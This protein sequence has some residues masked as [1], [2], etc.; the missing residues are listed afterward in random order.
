MICAIFSIGKKYKMQRLDWMKS[1][2]ENRDFVEVMKK[3]EKI[4]GEK[5]Y[6]P[7]LL[8]YLKKYYLW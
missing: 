1:F 3:H 6:V 4:V 5:I 8:T 2:S 7:I